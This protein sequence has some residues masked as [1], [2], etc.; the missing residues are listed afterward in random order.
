MKEQEPTPQEREALIKNMEMKCIDERDIHPETDPEGAELF[1]HARDIRKKVIAGTDEQMVELLTKA[2]ERKYWRA[3]SEL[4]ELYLYGIGTPYD[5]RK[6]VELL[7]EGMKQNIGRCYA[8]MANMLSKGD[9]VHQDTLAAFAYQRKAAELGFTPSMVVIGN[10]MREVG[11]AEVGVKVLECA[12]NHGNPMAAYDIGMRVSFPDD[13]E[14]FDQQKALRY[15]QKATE[16]GNYEAAR[17]M[18]GAFADGDINMTKDPE[19][20]KRYLKIMDYLQP[21]NPMGDYPT[22]LNLNAIVPLP[23][24]PLPKWDG[25]IERS[26]A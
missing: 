26:P 2:V 15:L 25:T 1:K 13:P 5:S 18:W 17:Q 19:R 20:A 4:A 10:K 12:A 3:Y 24:A 21:L 14:R 16:L 22:I 7:Q 6:A 11:A 23:P 8:L 9:G